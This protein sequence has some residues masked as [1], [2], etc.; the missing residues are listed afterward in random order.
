MIIQPESIAESLQ[1]YQKNMGYSPKIIIIEK[2]PVVAADKSEKTAK[3]ALDVF[4]DAM[5]I[6]FYS[7]YFGGP[8][9]MSEDQIR[10]I[11]N[12]EVENYRRKISAGN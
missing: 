6:S 1:I 5:K 3:L 12:W 2:G 8:H 7:N 11:E 10:F 4:L 9:F